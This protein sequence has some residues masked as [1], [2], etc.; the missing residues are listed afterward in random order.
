MRWSEPYREDSHHFWTWEPK[1]TEK[2]RGK[3]VDLKK[4]GKFHER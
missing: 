2:T 3:S 1:P 4:K